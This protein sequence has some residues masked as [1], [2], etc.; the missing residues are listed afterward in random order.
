M[1]S[2][3]SGALMYSASLSSAKQYF[4]NQKSDATAYAR[5]ARSK[6]GRALFFFVDVRWKCFMLKAYL[7]YRN[8]KRSAYKISYSTFKQGFTGSK[9]FVK[10][11]S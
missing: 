7:S 11:L 10:S 3:G 4:S 2:T 9:K 1:S 6:K 5:F 8:K